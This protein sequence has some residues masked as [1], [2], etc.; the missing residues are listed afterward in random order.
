MISKLGT[1][2]LLAIPAATMSA[3]TPTAV[4]DIYSQ[5]GVTA[6]RNEASVVYSFGS[7]HAGAM[8]GNVT[9]MSALFDEMLAGDVPTM[10]EGV[11]AEADGIKLSWNSVDKLIT[12]D[13]EA[14][15]VGHTEVLIADLNGLTRGLVKVDETPAQIS[16][17]DYATGV[18]IVGVAVD[19]KLVKSIK[20]ILK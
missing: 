6:L 13:C 12:V 8:D 9:L 18:Y 10:I 19:G 20:I 3:Q 7:W 4:Q 15:K 2:L 5:T 11:T 14:S 17:S 16:V 1:L